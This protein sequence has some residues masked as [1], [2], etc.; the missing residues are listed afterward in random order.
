M[1]ENTAARINQLAEQQG[2]ITRALAAMGDGRWLSSES[3]PD[4]VEGWLVALNPTW[5]GKLHGKVPLYTLPDEPED[6]PAADVVWRGSPNY[7]SGHR[8]MAVQALVIH[9]MAGTLDGCTSWFSQERSGVSSHYG[10]GL[11]GRQHQYV[12]LG[13]SSW[14]NGRLESGNQ[15]QYVIGNSIN[16]NYQTI[17]VETEDRGLGHTK[18]TDAM[19]DAT[20]AVCRL[21]I[22]R[23][24]GITYLF[25]HNIVSPNTRPQCC[26]DRWWESGRFQALAD[27]LGLEARY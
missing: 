23:Y 14:A 22:D 10:I 26:G 11:D 3:G 18:V 25:G 21:A 8:G 20:L 17:T 4:S 24:P 13:D 6:M 1:G 16:P 27:E 7:T 12:K 2:C 19:Y 9:T 5:A 15:W